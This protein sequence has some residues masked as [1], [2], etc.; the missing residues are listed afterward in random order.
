[1]RATFA[2]MTTPRRTL[3]ALA[4][5]TAVAAATAAIALG[6]GTGGPPKRALVTSQGLRA[7]TT[8]GTFCSNG[9]TE[10]GMGVSG[11]GD[12]AYPIPV[13]SYLPVTP[14]ST[15]RANVRKRAETLEAGLVHVEGDEMDFVGDDVSAKPVK[16]SH[17]RV[18]RLKL[19]ADLAGANVLSI[20]T[21]WASGGDANFWAGV[22]PVEQWP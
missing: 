22:K 20:S 16:G 8:V 19:P 6:G 14:G 11:C 12:A 3:I 13:R 9:T 10:N 17:R 2:R 15:V 1:L 7:G 21:A 18:W 4:I 5:A